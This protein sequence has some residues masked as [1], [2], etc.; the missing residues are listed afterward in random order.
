M[1]TNAATEAE[2]EEEDEGKQALTSEWKVIIGC[3]SHL[4]GLMVGLRIV[5][6]FGY[7]FLVG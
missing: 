7:R 3:S 5:L 6:S 1:V 4:L 2:A